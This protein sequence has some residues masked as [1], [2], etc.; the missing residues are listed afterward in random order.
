MQEGDFLVTYTYTTEIV[1]TTTTP[2]TETTTTS[3][4]LQDQTRECVV[5]VNG[6]A[7]LEVPTCE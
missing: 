1:E 2:R 6:V 5:T 3:A 7:D 4:V